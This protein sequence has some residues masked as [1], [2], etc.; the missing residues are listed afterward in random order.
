LKESAPQVEPQV[1]ATLKSTLE[2]EQQK[3]QQMA[4]KLV[5]QDTLIR[6][7]QTAV[8]QKSSGT[9]QVSETLEQKQKEVAALQASLKIKED[10]LKEIA[11]ESAQKNQ[12]IAALSVQLAS[13]GSQ[14][15]VSQ[16]DVAQKE[17]EIATLKQ[18]LAAREKELAEKG[19]DIASLQRALSQK[20]RRVAKAE[21]DVAANMGRLATP[22]DL[23]EPTGARMAAVVPEAAPQPT[24]VL[25]APKP[26]EIP[27]PS[28][29]QSD[30]QN[31]LQRAGISAGSIRM[32]KQPGEI[33]QYRWNTPE[34]SGVAQV[35]NS[36]QVGNA[37][38]F[39]NN[40]INEQKSRCAGDFAS[41]PASQGNGYSTYE[42]A[43]LGTNSSMSSS[44]IFFEKKGSVG[45]I[46][47]QTSADDMDIAMDARDKVASQIG[48]L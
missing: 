39:A 34:L 40:Y 31:V 14:S 2:T 9:E 25:Q 37:S 42:L 23:P 36:G 3:N 27:A 46:A 28:I 32:E 15:I 10:F 43:C 5:E 35:A 20:E 21:T 33:Y 30:I 38:Q 26:Q 24:Q 6:S 4:S 48:S 12:E 41:V 8:S 47:H 18:S 45:V 44:V 17:A 1:L 22:L 13:R 11:A 19:T 7:L 16:Q 29:G